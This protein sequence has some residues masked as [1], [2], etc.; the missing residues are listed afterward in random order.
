MDQE[1]NSATSGNLN[2]EYKKLANDVERELEAIKTKLK[3]VETK[4][5]MPAGNL[6]KNF[7][8]S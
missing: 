5:D 4:L 3:G 6:K 8:R 7:V 1:V 2:D